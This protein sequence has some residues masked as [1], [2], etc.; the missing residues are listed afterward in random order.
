MIRV[1][2]LLVCLSAVAHAAPPPEGSEDAKILQPYKAW[3]T[4][5]HDTSGRWCCDIGDGRPVDAQ[6][7]GDHWKV[8]ITPE[9]FPGEVDRWENV[10]ENKVTRNGNPMGL[11]ILWLYLGRI[12]CF[13]PPD[14]V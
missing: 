6:I 1:V 9:H 3:V 13:A 8:H 2:C 10:P 12:Q 4:T 7:E 11:S 5:Q 14:G